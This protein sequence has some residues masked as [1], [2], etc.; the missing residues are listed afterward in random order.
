VTGF[1]NPHFLDAQFF[2]G[3]A[4]MKLGNSVQA[5]ADLSNYVQAS[6]DRA[7]VRQAKQWL[8][9]LGRA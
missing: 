5:Q 1:E 9:Q 2:R 4:H 8:K 6:S 7:R 3:Q